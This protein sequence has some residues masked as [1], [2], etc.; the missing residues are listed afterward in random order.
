MG[1]MRRSSAE[2]NANQGPADEESNTLLMRK[3]WATREGAR[4]VPT[5]LGPSSLAYSS[6]R[7]LRPLPARKAAYLRAG[8]VISAPVPGLTPLRGPRGR[9]SNVPKPVI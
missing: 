8:M 1:R 4:G 9:V 6:T 3:L 5:G 2:P 7:S